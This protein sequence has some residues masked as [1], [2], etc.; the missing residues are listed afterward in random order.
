[1]AVL[2][3]LPAEVE[4]RKGLRRKFIVEKPGKHYLPIKANVIRDGKLIADT[5]NAMS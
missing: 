3:E 2:N 1:V 5:F 4:C